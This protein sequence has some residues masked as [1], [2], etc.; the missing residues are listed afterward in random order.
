MFFVDPTI[1]EVLYVMH[2]FSSAG[3]Y[4]IS[5]TAAN[6][7]GQTIQSRLEVVALN[8]IIPL[9]IVLTTSPENLIMK[10][11]DGTFSFS[12]QNTG[13]RIPTNVT[14]TINYNDGSPES[15]LTIDM[16]TP[17]TQ[18]HSYEHVGEH[19]LALTF[20]NPVSDTLTISNSI[21]IV[22]EIA[23]GVIHLRLIDSDAI[24]SPP[25]RFP[26]PTELSF[27]IPILSGSD[28]Q[29]SWT[30]EDGTLESHSD[31]ETVGPNPASDGNSINRIFG[32]PGFKVR[33]INNVCFITFT[34]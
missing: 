8:P 7:L 6:I 9:H 31:G 16:S 17:F 25:Y 2:T 30:F 14:L 10:L 33:I 29:L 26:I 12:L 22:E 3:A 1:D 13:R 19:N 15:T 34:K 23:L 5:A 27:E 32:L 21:N 4:I 28:V 20:N 24:L 18:S 11:G